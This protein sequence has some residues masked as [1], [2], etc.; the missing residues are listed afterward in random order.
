MPR[1]L[2][3]YIFILFVIS[4]SATQCCISHGRKATKI[5]IQK[6]IKKPEYTQITDDRSSQLI[7]HTGFIVNYNQSWR[8]PNWVGYQLTKKETSGPEKRSNSFMADPDADGVVVSSYDYKNSGYDK[9]HMAPAGDMKWSPLAMTESFYFSNICPQNHNLN[10]GDWRLLE[11]RCRKWAEEYDDIYIVC[12]PIVSSDHKTIGLNDIAVP[13]AFFKV[14][15]RTIA[16]SAVS[17]GFIFPNASGHKP[18]SAYAVS[19]DSVELVTHMDFFSCLPDSIEEK[20]E[21]TYSLSI[22]GLE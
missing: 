10:G 21:K 15:L 13:D 16:D 12:G 17:I 22:W 1:K 11:E 6:C 20:T 7:E 2:N 8:I 14:I 9:G 19:V 4:L 3:F 18:L 5:N